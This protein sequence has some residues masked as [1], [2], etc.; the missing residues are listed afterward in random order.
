MK[1]SRKWL[2][3]F[4]DFEA[5]SKEYDEK[6]TLSGSKVEL[7][8]EPSEEIKNVVVGKV[9]D[10]VRHENSDHMW[11]CQ[12]DAGTG[13]PIQIV[14]G[15]QNV[16]KGDLVPVAMHKSLLPGGVKIEKGKLRGVESC[17]MLCSLKE[18]GLDLHDF[19]D[20]I[21]DGIWIITEDGIKP[22]DDI[23]PIIGAD[24]SLVEFE[25]TN[26]RP[27]CFSMIG[28]ARETAVTFDK[29]L[30]L[31]EPVV[32]GCGGD[33]RE[34][35]S[36]EIKNSTLCPRYCARMVKNIKIAPSP[37]WMR[38]RLRAAGVRPI[39]NMVD[40]TNYV[41]LEYG[42]PMHAFDY[43][44]LNGGKIIVRNA[45]DG[46][47]MNT[48]DGTPRALTSSMLVIAD[49]TKPVGIAGVM[50]GENSEITESTVMAVFE[51]AN[52]NGTSIRRTSKALG[53][54]TDASGRYE[55]GLDPMNTLPAINRACELVEL[56]GAGEV[57]DGVIDVTAAEYKPTK[58]KLEPDKINKLLGTDIDLDFMRST[59]TKLGFELNGDMIT[60][61]SWRS[62]VERCADIA[63]EVGRFYGYNEIK[64]T[65]ISGEA[66]MGGYS[67]TQLFEREL[68]SLCRG[69]GYSEIM[70]YSFISPAAYE[71]IRE[72][73]NEK[74]TRSVSILNPLGEDTSV[75]RTTSLPSML[76]VLARNINLRNSAVSLYE[77]TKIY[78]PR[79]DEDLPEEK[80]CLTLGAYGDMDFYKIKGDVEAI[81]RELK[82]DE[83]VFVADKEKVSYHPGRCAK[84]SAGGKEIGFVGQI[85]P[86]VCTNY[87]VN[88]EIYAAQLDVNTLFELRKTD[89]SY[90]PMP[91]YPGI[92]RD[93]AVVCGGKYT[94][95]DIAACIKTAGGELL[96]NVEF[97]DVYTGAPIPA[98]FKSV[99]Y[100]LEFR[101]DEQNLTDKDI[102]PVMQKILL[103]LESELGAKLR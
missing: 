5:S 80:L 28:L 36:V 63:E 60:V 53:M 27:D 43:A 46:E 23:R 52:F 45:E 6:M 86:L 88:A 24:D 54:R 2:T 17:G 30:K 33:I 1:L 76:E 83:P 34:H 95:A 82:I 103:S 29:P 14:T 94:V 90:T 26:N 7:T 77:L 87:G 4:V 42:Q 67:K 96:K 8:E 31:H 39:N 15:A 66:M 85:H 64:A 48:L 9:L 56:L 78:L 22:G 57:I 65:K 55:K 61:P 62:D 97:F 75:M 12:I 79:E 91:K 101:S 3:E 89:L 71:K 58:L 70:T 100:S 69:L 59:L 35:L 32:K 74:I 37:K 16:K 25:I 10:I 73:G 51:S 41:M 84:I 93:L 49:S 72:G 40:I 44:C 92:L 68:G 102:E 99:A 20:A 19:P 38:Q 11:V 13:E 98:G 18:L 47:K 21:E 50:G 81:L